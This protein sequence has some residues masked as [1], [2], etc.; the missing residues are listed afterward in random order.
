MES[1]SNAR[2]THWKADSLCL[3]VGVWITPWERSAWYRR[4]FTNTS[5]SYVSKWVWIDGQK[6]SSLKSHS[7]AAIQ[8]ILDN[9]VRDHE[10]LGLFCAKYGIEIERKKS[11]TSF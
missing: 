2:I 8:P 9:L 4:E 3:E 1:V 5:A 7:N 6:D 10:T 11:D